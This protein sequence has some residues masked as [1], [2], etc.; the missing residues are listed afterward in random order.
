MLVHVT[1][2][3]TFAALQPALDHDGPLDVV[4][5][6]PPGRASPAH[7]GQ[8]T[9]RQ[10]VVGGVAHTLKHLRHARH[11][12][13]AVLASSS[14]VYG[15]QPHPPHPRVAAES[16]ALATHPR[17]RLLLDGEQL[18]LHANDSHA[19]AAFHVLRLAGLYGPGRVVG[20]HAIAQGHPLAGDPDAPLNLVHVDDAAAA[21]LAMLDPATRPAPIE[22]AAD[23]HPLPRSAY[24]AAL[25]DHLDAPPPRRLTPQQATQ[26]GIDPARLKAA[27]H[28]SLDPHTTRDRLGWQPRHPHVLEALQGLV[29]PSDP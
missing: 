7:A 29:P 5:L 26:L 24:Y 13:R 22:L 3:L 27:A 8:P 11:L 20:Q 1:Q 15:H 23:G 6:V 12:R 19:P 4:Y 9:A 14:A 16:P 17:A 18:W 2:P 21:L 10:T 25:A 28:K